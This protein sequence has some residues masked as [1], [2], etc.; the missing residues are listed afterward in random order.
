[1]ST[2]KRCLG[3]TYPAFAFLLNP[4]QDIIKIVYENYCWLFCQN[5]FAGSRDAKRVNLV[6]QDNPSYVPILCELNSIVCR[7]LVLGYFC[8]FY[9]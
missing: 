5:E 9:S 4:K 1:M 6:F 8:F 3:L 7:G 2:I